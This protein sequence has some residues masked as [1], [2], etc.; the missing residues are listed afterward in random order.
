MYIKINNE[1]ITAEEL[2]KR[3]GLSAPITSLSLCVNIPAGEL[4]VNTFNPDWSVSPGLDTFVNLKDGT[5]IMVAR[6]E[7]TQNLQPV[8]W[9]YN[10]T[11]VYLAYLRHDVRSD[12][13]FDKDPKDPVLVV[14]G[15]TDFNVQLYRENHYVVDNGMLP[16]D[17]QPKED[18][19]E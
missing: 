15:D 3:L 11:D 8:T 13:E 2:A 12:D 4:Q 9:L 5:S 18:D 19:Y 14:G 16:E 1:K 6:T 10:R 7:Q 17:M